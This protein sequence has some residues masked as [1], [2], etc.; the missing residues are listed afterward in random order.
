[1]WYLKWVRAVDSK[2]LEE[3]VN[4]WGKWPP[5]QGTLESLCETSGTDPSTSS[6]ELREAPEPVSLAWSSSS[7]PLIRDLY[8]GI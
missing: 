7:F 8:P 4:S 1:M 3:E 5:S 2:E 6:R